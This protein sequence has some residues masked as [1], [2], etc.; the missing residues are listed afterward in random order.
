MRFASLIAA[1]EWEEAEVNNP[2][3]ENYVPAPVVGVEA[4]QKRVVQQQVEVRKLKEY[5]DSLRKAA[6]A[7]GGKVRR[8][9]EVSLGKACSKR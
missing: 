3:P 1:S 2:D 4:L 9:E 8:S 7:L 5:M 6:N